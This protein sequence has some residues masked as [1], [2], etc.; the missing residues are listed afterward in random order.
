VTNIIQSIFGVFLNIIIEFQKMMISIKD[1]IGKMLGIVVTMLYILDG[2][3]KTMKSAWS[4]PPGKLIQSMSKIKIGSCFHPDTKVKTID[5]TIYKMKDLPIDAELVDGCS[6]FAKMIISNKENIKLFEIQGG[7]DNQT[8]YVTGEHC[9][10]NKETNTWGYVKDYPYAK[11]QDDVKC[12]YFSCLITSNR[13]IV[14]GE[15]LF[16]DWEDDEIVNN[17]INFN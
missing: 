12:E 11:V 2:S 3:V 13:E 10:F 15:H 8:I 14:I 4:G 7:I 9:I 6:V 5:G 17:M 1:T 16:W